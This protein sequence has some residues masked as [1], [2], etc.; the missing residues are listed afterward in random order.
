MLQQSQ[1]L[2][3]VCKVISSSQGLGAVFMYSIADIYGLQTLTGARID[4]AAPFFVI[5]SNTGVITV[6]TDLEREASVDGYHYYEIIVRPYEERYQ[7]RYFKED[8]KCPNGTLTTLAMHIQQHTYFYV[9][10]K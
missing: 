1:Y 6:N 8:V 9:R 2:E 3:P 10:L 4:I 5:N 7:T